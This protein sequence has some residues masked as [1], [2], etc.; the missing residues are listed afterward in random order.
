MSLPSLSDDLF[1]IANTN[2]QSVETGKDHNELVLALNDGN[3]FLV[4]FSRGNWKVNHV[5]HL[6]P[7][8]HQLFSLKRIETF[9]SSTTHCRRVSQFLNSHLTIRNKIIERAL[10]QWDVAPHLQDETVTFKGDCS[11]LEMDAELKKTESKRAQAQTEKTNSIREFDEFLRLNRSSKTMHSAQKKIKQAF[12]E[13]MVTKKQKV[14]QASKKNKFL[15]CRLSTLKHVKHPSGVPVTYYV[16]DNIKAPLIREPTKVHDDLSLKME[17]MF[18]KVTKLDCDFLELTFLAR[19]MFAKSFDVN[20]YNKLMDRLVEFPSFSKTR[21]IRLKTVLACNVGK[22]LYTHFICIGRTIDYTLFKPLCIDLAKVHKMFIF[23]RDIKPHNMTIKQNVTLETGALLP[24]ETSKLYFIDLDFM[25]SEEYERYEHKLGTDLYTTIKLM[26][27]KK[28]GDKK[29]IRAADN[30]ALLLTMIESC[31]DK[32]HQLG[33][34]D[35]DGLSNQT[36]DFYNEY[37]AP[38]LSPWLNK[39]IKPQY[40]SDVILFLTSPHE[41]PLILDLHQVIN[42]ST[43]H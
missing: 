36:T 10:E 26:E 12:A 38:V 3:R 28:R 7:D 14:E 2:F 42:W 6:N 32:A 41:Y 23:V 34:R 33:L 18:K 21:A 22:D 43:S 40:L 4:R 1:S 15:E 11:I 13:F 25:V 29:L 37:T 16:T 27:A 9:V 35:P 19:S 5:T 24:L 31:F 30:Y 20:N 17:G 8:N 39:V